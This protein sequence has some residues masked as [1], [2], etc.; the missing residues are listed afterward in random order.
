MC[1]F[2]TGWPGNHHV[3]LPYFGLVFQDPTSQVCAILHVAQE[4]LPS[5]LVTLQ[6]YCN[7]NMAL[8][9]EKMKEKMAVHFIKM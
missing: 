6:S 2:E 7:Q 8:S 1:L 3:A 5:P 9:W 4:V